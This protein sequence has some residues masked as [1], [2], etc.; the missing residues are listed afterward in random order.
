MRRALCVSELLGLRWEDVGA[1][2]LTIDERFCRG[3]ASGKG[4]G[5][6]MMLV[7]ER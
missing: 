1:D 4:Q 6:L 3:S 7:S 2:S 5:K